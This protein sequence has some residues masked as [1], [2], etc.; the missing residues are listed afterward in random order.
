M[1]ISSCFVIKSR[2][3]IDNDIIKRN[4]I[5]KIISYLE[6]GD[7]IPINFNNTFFLVKDAS[8]VNDT[9][10]IAHGYLVEKDGFGYKEL[11][12]GEIFIAL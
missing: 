4:Y 6:N 1:L 7:S 8:M 12:K 3:Y 5:C 9:L 2:R 10:C 11:S